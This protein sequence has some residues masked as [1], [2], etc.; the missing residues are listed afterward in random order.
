M[1]RRADEAEVVL[2][3]HGHGQV[4]G[5]QVIGPVRFDRANHHQRKHA[6]EPLP[7]RFADIERN[8]RFRIARHIGPLFTREA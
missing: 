6:E 5:R 2:P 4:L 1:A 7:D 3:A 8:G